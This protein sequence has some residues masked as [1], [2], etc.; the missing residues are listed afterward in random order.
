MAN[1]L[2][3]SSN[4]I[5]KA[6]AGPAIRVWEFANALSR[7]HNVVVAV[8]NQ[9]EKQ[10]DAFRL[11]FSGSQEWK[12]QC[13]TPDVVIAQMLT[14][15]Q[16]LSAKRRGSAIILDV[17][18]PIPLEHFELFK[19]HSMDERRARHGSL[20][21]SLAFNFKMADGFICASEKQ[22]DLWIGFLLAQGLID[23][24]TY[25]EDQTLRHLIDVVP[26]GLPEH[27][28]QRTG[29]GIRELFKL[30]Q[31][32]KII[33]WGGGIWN[34]FDPLTLIKAMKL[35]SA[36]NP[37]VKLV[38]MGLKHPDPAVPEMAMARQTVDL[39]RSLGLIDKTVFFN[40]G[41]VPY[42]ERQNFLL[43]ADIG[44]ST[45]FDHL[46]T[47][48]SFRTRMLDYIW[49]KLPILATEGDSFADM[50][51]RHHLGV[52]V[53]YQDEHAIAEAVLAMTTDS[54]KIGEMKRSLAGMQENL[55]WNRVVEPLQ[56]MIDR[57][58]SSKKSMHLF[59]MVRECSSAVCAKVREKGVV[60]CVKRALAN[61]F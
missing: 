58:P 42:E 29:P 54:N 8:P 23:P 59:E 1:V 53:P 18:D 49:S 36:S 19:N 26:F 12:R 2:I 14:I 60:A 4:I 30:D 15:K 40:F 45:H 57:L 25:A 33:L 16:A 52:V 44:V 61:R 39:A 31:K 11:V 51:R 35:L 3:H 6:M 22:R 5:G 48:F 28:P 47:R 34:W 37:N 27:P 13:P 32:D 56:S 41:W 46:E 55:H 7:D 38:F 17:Y 9:P 20:M 21:T 10:P 43:D 50:V 24:A